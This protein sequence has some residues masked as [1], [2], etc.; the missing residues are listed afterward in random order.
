MKRCGGRFNIID[1]KYWKN[2]QEDNYRNN[3]FQLEEPLKTVDE[4]LKANKGRHYTKE[5]LQACKSTTPSHS[6]AYKI[7]L[8]STV[9]AAVALLAVVFVKSRK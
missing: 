4:I 7:M 2:N 9:F 8:G 5:M 6:V 3:Q 1:N